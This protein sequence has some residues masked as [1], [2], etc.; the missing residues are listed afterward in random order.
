ML[1]KNEK[2][3][4]KV[5]YE[6]TVNT[7]KSIIVTEDEIMACLPKKS[8]INLCDLR[9]ILRQLA[10]DD[11]FELINS[12]KKGQPVLVIT[13]T[14]NGEAFEREMIQ[15]KRNIRQKLVISVI[16]AIITA[17]VGLIIKGI[18]S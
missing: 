1:N 13:L 7:N 14:K 8:K 16:C 10:I 9:N 3:V 17:V 5:I 4:M 15:Q 6:K 18:F 11:Y 2:A 12:E